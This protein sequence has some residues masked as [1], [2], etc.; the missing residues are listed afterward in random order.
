MWLI[1]V[2]EFQMKA[3]TT[4]VERGQTLSALENFLNT[5]LREESKVLRLLANTSFGSLCINSR[6]R[7]KGEARYQ[8]FDRI[9]CQF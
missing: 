2:R 9:A 8:N 5:S 7:G 4:F 1:Y 6:R 3:K